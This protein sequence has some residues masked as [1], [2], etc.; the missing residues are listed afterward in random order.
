[1]YKTLPKI[2]RS[3]EVDLKGATTGLEYKGT[4]TVRCVL[5]IG[6]KHQVEL[7]KSRLTGD[8]R[9]PTNGLANIAVTL[10]EIHGRVVEAPAFWKDL[11]NGAEILDEDVVY[12]IYN[13]CMDLEDQWKSELKK[14]GEEAAS[15]N[16]QT[17]SP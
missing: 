4:F 13:K 11:K 8:H 5:N 6:Q 7:E 15:K 10:A 1:M 17:V 12:E 9:N 14:A 16:V 2:D 3:F